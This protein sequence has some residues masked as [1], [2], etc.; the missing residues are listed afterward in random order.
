[1]PVS[2]WLTAC[3]GSSDER[4]Y[5]YAGD[6]QSGT[7]NEGRNLHPVIE[8]FGTEDTWI[9]NEIDHPCIKQLADSLAVTGGHTG[10]VTPESIYDLHGNIN[11]WID[12]ASGAF[13]GGYYYDVTTNGN[14]CL[15]NT[16]ANNTS[17]YDYTT[18][19]RCCADKQL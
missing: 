7:C 9:W 6:Y 15:Y 13:K 11:E 18:G 5:P 17:H 1:M 4:V 8:Y 2:I 3:R 19:F 16:T 12:D 10:C 14:G